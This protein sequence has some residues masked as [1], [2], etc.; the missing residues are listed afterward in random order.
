M[1]KLI[2]LTGKKFGR[3]TVIER[4]E[5][6]GKSTMWLCKCDCGNERIVSRN[7]LSTGHSM[8]CGCLKKETITKIK[9][10]HGKRDTRLYHIWSSMKGRCITTSNHKYKNYGGRGITICEE[11]LNDFQAF[12]DWAMANGYSDDLSIDRI[13]VN[14]NYEPSNCRWTDAKTQMNNMTTNRLITYNGKTQTVSQWADETGI[15]R[16]TL[17]T[18]FNLGWEEE[19]ALTTKNFEAITYNNQTHT[20]PEWSKITGIEYG[21]LKAR[22]SK[23]GWSVERALTEKVDNT[24]FKEKLYTFNG[25][26][27][28]LKEWSKE[29]GINYRTLTCRLYTHKWPIERVLSQPVK[30]RTT[31]K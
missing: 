6:K 4:T 7:N 18:R 9:T 22:L 17:I 28:T 1:S 14:G 16:G 13:D 8:S 2:D 30:K 12:Y 5:N 11:W 27:L 15:N 10:T 29:L 19:R 23:Y 25:K 31:K 21:T 20:I 26:A 3:L 24:I